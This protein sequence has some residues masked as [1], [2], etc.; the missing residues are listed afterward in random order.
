MENASL[1]YLK[2]RCIGDMSKLNRYIIEVYN[3]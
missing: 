1:E 3:D 2:E